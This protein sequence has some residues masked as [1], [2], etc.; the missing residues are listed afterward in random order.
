MRSYK[1]N[2]TIEKNLYP[3]ERKLDEIEEG[4]QKKLR[5]YFNL[6]APVF[7]SALLTAIFGNSIVS[8][9]ARNIEDE[10]LT[11]FEKL[12]NTCKDRFV[13]LRRV[14]IFLYVGNDV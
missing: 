3:I 8:V 9:N 5:Q 7:L 10:S 1:L 14:L 2:Q 13:P 4:N 12:F 6:Y 11:V